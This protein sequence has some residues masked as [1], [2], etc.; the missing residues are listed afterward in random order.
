MLVSGRVSNSSS[1]LLNGV[2]WYG[3]ICFCFFT[4]RRKQKTRASSFPVG[5]SGKIT[6][7]VI[8]G[9]HDVF[10]IIESLKSCLAT[11]CLENSRCC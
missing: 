6:N 8:M 5:T 10:E 9:L 4:T 7:T 2:R 3:P 1:N 11:D